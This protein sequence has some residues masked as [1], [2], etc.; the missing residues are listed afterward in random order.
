MISDHCSTDRLRCCLTAA[1]C[2]VQTPDTGH[3]GDNDPLDVVEV[4]VRAFGVG[5]IVPVRVRC[6]SHAAAA[7]MFVACDWH[8]SSVSNVLHAFCEVTN[9]CLCA[10]W[11]AAAWRACADR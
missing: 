10:V 2:V 9:A 1:C 7:A 8:L 4:G 6:V 3:R 11:V 5:E